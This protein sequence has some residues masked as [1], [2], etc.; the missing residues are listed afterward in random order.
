M[1]LLDIIVKAT[2]SGNTSQ[3]LTDGGEGKD[4]TTVDISN[5]KLTGILIGGQKSVDWKFEPQGDTEYTIYDN[6]VVSQN[7]PD[8]LPITTT[9]ND[10]MNHTLVLESPGLLRPL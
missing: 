3:T 10:V 4:A 9:G 8:G 7:K 6:I 2:D 1:G 5:I